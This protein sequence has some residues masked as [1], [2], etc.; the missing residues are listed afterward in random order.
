MGARTLS[1][2]FLVIILSNCNAV[3]SQDDY[4][5]LDNPFPEHVYKQVL[6]T[7]MQIWEDI[8]SMNEGTS[9]LDEQTADDLLVGR[10]MRLH[11]LVRQLP[12]KGMLDED[13]AYL[14]NILKKITVEYRGNN[15]M[16]KKSLVLLTQVQ[17][18]QY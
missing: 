17:L 8:Q 10:L 4:F 11:Q 1:L 16:A 12:K 2:L 18:H 15:E 6:D 13:R 7:S 5:L 14:Q 9:G 3:R